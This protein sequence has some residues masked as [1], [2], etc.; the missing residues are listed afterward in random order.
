MTKRKYKNYEYPKRYL[1]R[2][3]V[4]ERFE[5][6]FYITPGCWIWTAYKN[7]LGYGRF[8]N[9]GKMTLAHR[10]SYETY[11]GP[12]PEADGYHGMT[13][14]HKCDNPACVNPDHLFLGTH[15][16]NMRDMAKKQRS[17]ETRGEA[18]GMAKLTEQDIV[19]IRNDQRSQR[20]IGKD[21]GIDQKT[22]W[23]IKHN[24]IWRHV[25]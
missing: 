18:N 22:V 20:T 9:K 23:D 15:Q 21:Y 12:I 8:N 3:T 10:Y 14:C 16:E 6:K 11:V 7:P 4:K 24:R 5:L 2:L 17:A 13:V 1:Y 19:N 25:A